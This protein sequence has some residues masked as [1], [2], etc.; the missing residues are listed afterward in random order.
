[1]WIYNSTLLYI[2]M[3]WCLV[4][5]RMFFTAW[6]L[7]KNRDNFTFYLFTYN[8]LQFKKNMY[9]ALQNAP[10]TTIIIHPSV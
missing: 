6:Y 3:T 9:T 8:T 5:Y 4:Q 1:V 2:F 10:N 7:V